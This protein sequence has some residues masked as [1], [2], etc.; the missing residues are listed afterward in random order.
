L[1]DQ[2]LDTVVLP[3]V[4]PGGSDAVTEVSNTTAAR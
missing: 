4:L 1:Y 2:M 3:N